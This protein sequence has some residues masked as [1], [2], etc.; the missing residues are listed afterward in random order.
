MQILR[1]SI[2]TNVAS[3]TPS[4]PDRALDR[5]DAKATG[6]ASG[7]WIIPIV[8]LGAMA[9]VAIFWVLL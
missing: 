5:P 9:W 2:V 6:L 1:P 7:W 8:I 3:E 4:E